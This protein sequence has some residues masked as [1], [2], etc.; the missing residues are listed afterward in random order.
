MR[1]GAL[2]DGE[3]KAPTRWIVKGDDSV[4]RAGAIRIGN[5]VWQRGVR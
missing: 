3:S 1:G 4:V 5:D 2:G